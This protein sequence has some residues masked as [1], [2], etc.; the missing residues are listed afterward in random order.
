MHLSVRFENRLREMQDSVTQVIAALITVNVSFP[1][2]LAQA[3]V[4]GIA[5]LSQ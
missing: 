4:A 1:L 2:T 3:L 5:P